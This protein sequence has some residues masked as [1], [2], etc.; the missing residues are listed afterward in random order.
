MKQGNSDKYA[1]K[2]RN[3]T[4][5]YW[6]NKRKSLLF[7]KNKKIVIIGKGN[8]IPIGKTKNLPGWGLV[9]FHENKRLKRHLFL[10]LINP[11]VNTFSGHFWLL[12]FINR[13]ANEELTVFSNRF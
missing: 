3:Y 10:N 2:G 12:I 1:L 9:D 5:F 4:T 11:L 7:K 8:L 6:N 13:Q